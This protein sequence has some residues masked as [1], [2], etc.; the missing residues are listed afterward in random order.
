MSFDLETLRES[1]RQGP[2]ARVVVA[3]T[4]GSVPRE[5]GASMIVTANG[6]HGTIGG[7]ALEYEAIG[8]A[9]SALQRGGNRFDKCPLGPALG[10]CCG[11]AV[12]LLIEVWDRDSLE[13]LD[14]TV[15][16]RPLPDGPTARPVSV[17][18]I[19][20][21]ARSGSALPAAG[22]VDGWMVE[23][24]T[25]QSRDIWIW[26]AGH[27]GRG[28]VDTLSNMPDFAVTWCDSDVTRFPVGTSE[29]SARLIAANPADLVSLAGPTVEHFVLTYSHALDLEICHRVLGQPFLHLGLIGSLTKR[30][31]FRSRLL[32]LG[33]TQAQIDRIECPIG[34]PAL[35]K[36]PEE[37]A[38]GV[39]VGLLKGRGR[40]TDNLGSVAE[41]A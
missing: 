35:G 28:I 38:L 24:I 1:V 22:V 17:H 37:I 16:V 8:R 6:F 21:Q 20:N 2:V 36:R 18:R 14:E 5:V 26:G 41:E 27:V 25:R 29:G 11:G 12:S 33:H 31:R 23:P 4:K 19:V 13:R 3:S 15:V 40:S 34:D 9:R 7:G 30:V 39:A 10:Q 32:A